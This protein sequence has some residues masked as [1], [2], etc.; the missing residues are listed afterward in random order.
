MPGKNLLDRIAIRHGTDKGTVSKKLSPKN[1]TIP[2]YEFFGPLADLPLNIL[3][4]GI[5]KGASLRTWREFF[6][7][8]NLYAVDIRPELKNLEKEIPNLRVFIGDQRDARFWESFLA[9]VKTQFQIIIDDGLHD[10][11]Y[12]ALTFFALWL[13]VMPGYFYCIEDLHVGY[14]DSTGEKK[15]SGFFA[16]L[17]TQ[18]NRRRDLPAVIDIEELHLYK[19]LMIAKKIGE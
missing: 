12:Q 14:R 19:S 16:E 18:V 17:I 2:Y 3:E 11:T 5:G 1:Y 9:Q 7:K 6:P 13:R 15:L 8:A 10:P 4:I